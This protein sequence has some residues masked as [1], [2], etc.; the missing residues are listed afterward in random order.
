MPPTTPARHDLYAAIHKALRHFM[1][2]TLMRLSRVDVADPEDLQQTLG[3]LDE[4]LILC[5][6]HLHNEN[7]FIHPALEAGR[8]GVSAR[9]GAEHEEH[10]QAIAELQTVQRY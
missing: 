10:V 3:Q 6:Q 8:P 7:S 9:I 2:D 1:V 4:L 5:G